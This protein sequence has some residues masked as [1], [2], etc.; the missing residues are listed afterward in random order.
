MGGGVCLSPVSVCPED[1]WGFPHMLLLDPKL[2]ESMWP[3]Q[4]HVASAQP[5]NLPHDPGASGLGPR[6]RRLSISTQSPWTWSCGALVAM[7]GQDPSPSLHCA[8]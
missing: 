5:L 8:L 7:E 2:G 4:G 6:T 1:P 3:L